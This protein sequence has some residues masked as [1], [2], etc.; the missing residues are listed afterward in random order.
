M[1]DRDY[2]LRSV[3][4]SREKMHEHDGGPFAAVIVLDGEIVGEGWNRVTSSNDPTAHAE[5]DAIRDACHRLGTF[6]LEGAVIYTSCEPCP[7]CLAAIYWARI[8]R[9]C[10]ANT[11]AEAAGI[12]FDDAFLFAQMGLPA[13]DRAVPSERLHLAEAREVFAEWASMPDKVT[14]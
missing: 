2:M 6:S 7:M 8:S 5:V 13:G 3:E 11:T 4:L 1:D 10:F 14:Y 12:G 9:I